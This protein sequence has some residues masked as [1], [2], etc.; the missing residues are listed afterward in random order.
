MEARVISSSGESSEKTESQP[1]VWLAVQ[2]FLVAFLW[3]MLQMPFYV[4]D[5]MTAWAV[6]KSCALASLGDAGIMV[7][8]AWIADRLTGGGLWRER[9]TSRPVGIFL[10]VGLAA[11]A[12]IEWMALRS[13]WGW[14]YAQSMPTLLG[15]G[16][17]PLAMWVVVP[18]A[19]LGLARRMA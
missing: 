3:E 16:V 1:E 10:G 11:T 12:A 2:G 4:M 7:G 17:V 13:D 14:S 8:A 18:L 19:S 6:T 5:G 9:L 15:I